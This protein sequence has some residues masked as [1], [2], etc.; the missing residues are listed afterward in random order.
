MQKQFL[1]LIKRGIINIDLEDVADVLLDKT[2]E[3][4]AMSEI[5]IPK[6]NSLQRGAT[7]TILYHDSH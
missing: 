4:I 3:E 2:Q 5:T 6:I 7:D 1:N